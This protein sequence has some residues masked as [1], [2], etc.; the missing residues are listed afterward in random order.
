M[1]ALSGGVAPE[2]ASAATVYNVGCWTTLRGATQYYA[3]CSATP[4]TVCP[5]TRSA[6]PEVWSGIVYLAYKKRLGAY[7]GR[8][9]STDTA[10][11]DWNKVDP[12][13]EYV[14][15]GGWRTTV[16]C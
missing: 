12:D 16:F 15:F 9:D 10:V 11:W 4:V 14:T 2:S 8:A 3:N 5:A 6:S 1:L 13:P 7:T